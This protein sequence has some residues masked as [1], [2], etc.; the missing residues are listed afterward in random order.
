MDKED[1]IKE[2]ILEENVK[3]L[4]KASLGYDIPDGQEELIRTILYKKS[5][6]ISVSAMTRY[7][8]SQAVSLAIALVIKM[9][10]NTKIAFI[11]PKEEQAGILRQYMAELIL[12]DP[13]L[14]SMADISKEGKIR[15]NK[16]ASKKRMTFS[17][18]CEYRVFSAEGDANRLMGFGIGRGGIL[19]CDES[20][21]ISNEA[22]TKIMRM[23]GDD[24]EEA[25]IIELYNPWSRDNKAFEHTLDPAYTVFHIDWRQAVRESRTTEAFIDEQRRG[26]TP[27]EFEVLY[28]SR[29]PMESEDSVFNLSKIHEAENKVF[30]FEDELKKYEEIMIKPYVYKES[31]VDVAR[32][33]IKNFV[34]IISVDPADKGLD[35]TVMFWGT[36]KNNDYSV[37]GAWSEAKSESMTLVGKIWSKA[38]EYIGRVVKGEIIIDRIGIGTGAYS[39]L[40]ELVIEEGYDNIK[41]IGAHFGEKAKKDDFFINKKAENYFRLKDLFNQGMISIPTIDKL[42]KDLLSMKW[43]LN[44]TSKVKII[45]PKDKSPDWAD[46]LVYMCWSEFK[47]ALVM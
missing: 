5:K 36:K 4:V 44:S 25:M 24:P 14:L 16:E 18:G 12:K 15:I 17:N 47:P 42:R 11:G 1:I 23:L 26:M 35:E 43:E 37:V 33:Q 8:K 22:W 9:I 27:L 41:V 39:R 19:V 45:D 46:S 7:G 21:L 6:R 28:E 3:L 31:E 20:C 38:K 29:F 13:E 2:A 10:P 30:V 40:K 34:R 32:S